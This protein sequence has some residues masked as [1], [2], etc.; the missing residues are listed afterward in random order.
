MFEA[1]IWFLLIE[2]IGI[3]AL[4]L[5]FQ[6]FRFLPERG[7]TLTKP[8]GLLGTG[9]LVWLVSMLGLPF[10]PAL[11]WAA[12]IILF[13]ALD[14]WLL[15][16]QGRRLLGEIGGW[17]ARHAWFVVLVE[18][19]FLLAYA[20]LLNM[21]SY[22]PE[23]RDYE[24]FGDFAFV[25]SLTLND[26]MPPSDPWMSGYPI[27]YYYFSHFM[28]AMLLKMTGIDPDIGFNLIIAL[29]F[30]LTCLAVFGLGYNMARLVQGAGRTWRHGFV[31]GLLALAMVC[32]LGNLDSVRQIFWPNAA[33]GE[34]GIT[35]F[36]FSW[37]N[38]SRVIWDYMPDAGTN[39][40]TYTWS[41]TINEFPQFSFIIADIH[42]HVMT[43]PFA[44]LTIALALNVLVTP[45]FSPALNLRKAEGILFFG[46]AAVTVGA[47]YFLNT[48]D[49]PTYLLLLLLAALVRVRLA[50][51]KVETP[52]P[53]NEDEV[54]ISVKESRWARVR[55][56][57]YARW[58]AW[59]A[60]LVAAS[61]A[62]YLP[63]HLT[64]VS[65]VGDLPVPEPVASIPVLGSIAKLILFVA[66]DRTPLL[67]YLLV[68]GLFVF[69]I[70]SFLVLKLWP[71]L[72]DP[73]AYLDQPGYAAKSGF[74]WGNT[75]G[76]QL[77][78]GGIALFIIS[79]IAFYIFKLSPLVTI[80]LA[81]VSLPLLGIGL[82]LLGL[83][84][85]ERYR[86]ERRATEVRLAAFV[87][88]ALMVLGGWILRFELYG[89]LLIVAIACGLLVWFE[90]RP[91]AGRVT[92]SETTTGDATWRVSVD[93]GLVDR[94]A[95][96]LI[97]LAVVIDF[98]TELII[99]RDVFNSRLNTLFKFYYQSWVL[100]G[101]A[102]AYA[103]WR[104]ISWAWKLA[105]F[106]NPRETEPLLEAGPRPAA[107]PARPLP[108]TALRLNPAF[109]LAGG[110]NLAFSS[111]QVSATPQ[112][113][114]MSGGASSLDTLGLEDPEAEEAEDYVQDRPYRPWWRW[115]WAFGLGLCLLG[116][117]VFPI[118]GA[119]EKTNHYVQRVG[120]DGST[121]LRDGG[122]T[123]AGLPQDYPAIVWLK[124]QIAA[125]PAFVKPILEASGQ[126]W[127]DY[128]R[129]STFTGLPTLMGW[130]GHE[131][132]W[133]G[134]KANA[135]RDTFDCGL[136]LAK[137]NMWP[138]QTGPSLQRDEPGCRLRL[139][140]FVYSTDDVQLAQTLLRAA[141]VQYVYVGA[142]EQGLINRG[143]TTQKQY[144]PQALGKFAQFMRVIYQ[145]NGVTIYRF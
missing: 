46:V 30:A 20:Y 115:L 52:P 17:L 2:L 68:F 94:F 133:R 86:L 111:L 45:A 83:E 95:L 62:L 127:V 51:K 108:Q 25:K 31:Y 22:T 23:I 73:Y 28:M 8:L 136:L 12:L 77:A 105:P 61:L 116:G 11:C 75:W 47:L 122:T 26:K 37:W 129:V 4:P 66:W 81:I 76:F 119:Y 21:R 88:G 142:L 103:S 121:W 125:N 79:E 98:G 1:L 123:G 48:W 3:A 104:V 27:N 100:F 34:T 5:A 10:N 138:P 92:V 60:G 137:Y 39:G 13:G 49:Y 29:V 7:Y 99:I 58:T 57:G 64:F 55:R 132:Q 118:F 114:N 128:S 91:D 16:R 38:P 42:P 89:P 56:N 33:N 67:G 131:N 50:P 32:V 126:D 54:T 141:G 120:L 96:L 65:L 14:G 18:L 93:F 19:V 74:E 144:S 85:L 43:L 106:T 135:R 72:K 44:L 70:L 110:G 134:G 139:I 6:V 140:D 40:L 90:N 59:S 102:A 9:Y 87:L 109:G 78:T 143:G 63:F 36:A 41:Q 24:K 15:L 112:A 84:T 35:N 107:R 130:P 145:A 82:A 97:L 69:P 113:L 124:S 80:S 101:L 53:S 71:Y 117:L